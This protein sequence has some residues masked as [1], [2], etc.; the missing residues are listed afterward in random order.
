MQIGEH[1]NSL[2][3]RIFSLGSHLCHSEGEMDALIEMTKKTDL[4]ML[5]EVIIKSYKEMSVRKRLSSYVV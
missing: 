4:V 2:A 3:C 5:G 1:Y